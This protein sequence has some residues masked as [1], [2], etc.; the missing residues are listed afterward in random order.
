MPA[1]IYIET[2]GGTGTGGSDDHAGVDIGRTFTETPPLPRRKSF[3]ATSARAAPRPTATRAAPRSGRTPRWLWQRGAAMMPRRSVSDPGRGDPRPRCEIAE[4]VMS[5]G[6]VR[7]GRRGRPGTR[8]T[9]GRCSAPSSIDRTG[10]AR[11]RPDRPHAVRRVQSRASSS[12]GPGAIHERRLREVVEATVASSPT[13]RSL[14]RSR[15]SG[16]GDGPDLFA[17]RSRRSPM[18]RRRRS[19]ARRRRSSPGRG[20]VASP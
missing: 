14:R 2:H 12:A 1:A 7:S 9:R 17:P 18:P 4:R 5:E 6:G 13:A 16:G 15:R 20:P 3:C 10:P 11:P 8:R 19:S